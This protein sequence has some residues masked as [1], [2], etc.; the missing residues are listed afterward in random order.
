MRPIEDTGEL[1]AIL[2]CFGQSDPAARQHKLDHDD[3]V[4]RFSPGPRAYPA[5]TK[6]KMFLAHSQLEIPA[7]SSSPATVT[8]TRAA[9]SAETHSS[10][11]QAWAIQPVVH[12]FLIDSPATDTATATDHQRR[13]LR[14]RAKA[15]ARITAVAASLPITF[16]PLMAKAQ[17][18]VLTPVSQD[19]QPESTTEER[20][21]TTTEVPPQNVDTPSRGTG[22]APR[23]VD[24]AP[25]AAAAPQPAVDPRPQ[26]LTPSSYEVDDDL[27][28]TGNLLWEGLKG[29]YVHLT[30]NNGQLVSGKVVAH[31]GAAVA[32]ARSSDQLVVSVA[33]QDVREVRVEKPVSTPP[34]ETE[35][36]KKKIRRG[37]IITSLSAPLLVSGAVFMAASS[38]YY[39]AV[40]IPLYLGGIA[41]LAIGIPTLA[42][43]ARQ[44]RKWKAKQK[45]TKFSVLPG[46]ARTRGGWNGGLTMRF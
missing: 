4:A 11:A 10:S 35:D 36:G 12:G 26:S 28:L 22:S 44:R 5:D 19:H 25:Q 20:P 43:G 13:G 9:A 38:F 24:P 2:A 39:S 21:A 7:P 37:L 18:T 46:I 33:K 14:G 1:N 3:L 16:S 17:P 31:T 42:K 34:Q 15:L 32:V 6:V 29:L 8:D 40:Y 45:K 41:M 30:M 27:Q 23:S